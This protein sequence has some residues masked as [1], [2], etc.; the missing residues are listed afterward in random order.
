MRGFFKLSKRTY[1]CQITDICIREWGL[2]VLRF[3]P[4]VAFNFLPGQFLS[5]EVPALHKDEETV[6]RAYS[7]ALP[8]ELSKEHGYEVCIKIQPN[9][10]AGKYLQTLKL[11]AWINIRAS[12]G[13]FVYRS[14]QGRGVCFISTGTGVAPLRSIALSKQ[15]QKSEPSHSIAFIGSRTL[16]ELPYIGD[17]ERAGITTIYPLSREAR[18]IEYPFFKGRVTDAIRKVSADFPWK[19]TDYYLCGSASMISEVIEILL[20]KG[21]SASSIYSEA[22]ESSVSTAVARVA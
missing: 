16:E 4:Q 6:Y 17:F 22:F 1:R 15:F 2:V 11:G 9:G 10:R 20:Q 3:R 21:V 14:T 19:E 18:E 8:Y 5:L 12:Y 7:F 13:D